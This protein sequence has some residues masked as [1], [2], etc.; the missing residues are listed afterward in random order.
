M[1]GIIRKEGIK[2]D[3][4]A[5]SAKD[6]LLC[7]TTNFRAS[8]HAANILT[9]ENISFSKRW[10]RIPLLQREQYQGNTEMCEIS[11]NRNEYSRARRAISKL[12]P[13]FFNRLQIN[14]I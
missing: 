3:I 6:V 13:C 8:K 11:I 2:M 5:C 10:N 14:V 9:E 12:E 4:R 7:S 1:F